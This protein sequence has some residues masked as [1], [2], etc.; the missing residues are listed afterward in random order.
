MA[1][2]LNSGQSRTNPVSS[3]VDGL[4]PQDHQITSPAPWSLG[5]T[6][7]IWWCCFH[8]IFQVMIIH[9]PYPYN[10]CTPHHKTQSLWLQCLEIIVQIVPSNSDHWLAIYQKHAT[11]EVAESCSQT[12]NEPLISFASENFCW[13]WNASFKGGYFSFKSG[14]TK[15]FH[16]ILLTP[17]IHNYLN[18]AIFYLESLS[19]Q[20]APCHWKQTTT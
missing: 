17:Q 9:F 13:R 15:V 11:L 4:S 10:D 7:S 12:Q 2:E 3:R 1:E 19:Q 20:Q 5:H 8:T 14:Q 6:T 16:N 18:L